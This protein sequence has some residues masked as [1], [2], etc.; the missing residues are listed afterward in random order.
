[1]RLISP[2]VSIGLA[3]TIFGPPVFAADAGPAKVTPAPNGTAAADPNQ[4][5]KCRKF[6]VT[7]SLVRKT[8]VCKTAAEW[9]RLEDRGNDNARAIVESGNV[10]SGGAC[11]GN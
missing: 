7:G 9:R 4:V 10:C 6:E 8:R 1:M 3:L 5:V 2:A 11:R